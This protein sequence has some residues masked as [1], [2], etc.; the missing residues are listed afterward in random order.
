MDLA[1]PDLS[2]VA[3]R[4]S[5]AAALHEGEAMFLTEPEKARETSGERD[6]RRASTGMD[7]RGLA[8][9]AVT[10]LLIFAGLTFYYAAEVVGVERRRTTAMVVGFTDRWNVK[11]GHECV[12]ELGTGYGIARIYTF[13]LCHD[14]AWHLGDTAEVGAR[15]LRL[16]GTIVVDTHGTIFEGARSVLPES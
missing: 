4:F 16:T 12:T 2:D 14:A 11:R 8:H 15:Q 10:M 6:R 9:I 3:F 13:D 7:R 1:T 5:I